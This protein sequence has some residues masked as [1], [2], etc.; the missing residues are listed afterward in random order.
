[1]IAPNRGRVQFAAKSGDREAP[2]S[3]AAAASGTTRRTLAPTL[4]QHLFRKESFWEL[5]PMIPRRWHEAIE[6]R[7][8]R[9]QMKYTCL[10]VIF[11]AASVFIQAVTGKWHA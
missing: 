9:I 5:N 8:D 11:I 2:A 10:S 1:L 3:R 6:F 7:P 4:G